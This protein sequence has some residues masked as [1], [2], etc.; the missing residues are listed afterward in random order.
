MTDQLPGAT[1]DTADMLM[2]HNLFRLL[3]TQARPLILSVP[4]ADT[5]RAELVTSH[6]REITRTLHDHHVTEDQLLWD[7]LIARAPACALHV[8]QM[9]A[10][11]GVVAALTEEL[12]ELLPAFESTATAASRRAVM[13]TFDGIRTTLLLHLG[14][15]EADILPIVSVTLTQA[16]WDRIGEAA[17]RKTPRDRVFVQLGWILTS[18]SPEAGQAWFRK[19]LPLPARVAYKAIGRRQ[20][21]AERRRLF[22]PPSVA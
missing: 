7:D 11:H 10:Q 21:E 5:A 16:E 20:F 19:K 14:D 6:L 18:M 4:D 1:C 9:R 22:P 12:E 17:R 2:V 3:F 15:E 13:T 8:D